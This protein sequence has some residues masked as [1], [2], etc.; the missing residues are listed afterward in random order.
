MDITQRALINK[1]Y[2]LLLIEFLYKNYLAGLSDAE[3]FFGC[4]LWY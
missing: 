1:K 2:N 4:F 3:E